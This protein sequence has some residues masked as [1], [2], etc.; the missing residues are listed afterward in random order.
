MQNGSSIVNHV[1]F[2][3]RQNNYLKKNICELG[4][5]IQDD[6]DDDDNDRVEF[7]IN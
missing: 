6:D 7:L 1:N 3:L 4:E 5:N 2:P